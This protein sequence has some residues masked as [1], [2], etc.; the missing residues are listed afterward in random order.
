MSCKAREIPNVVWYPNFPGPGDSQEA[1][2]FYLRSDA[3]LPSRENVRKLLGVLRADQTR[4]ASA[5]RQMLPT[6]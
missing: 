5:P 2:L 1:Q 4:V 3:S 6:E